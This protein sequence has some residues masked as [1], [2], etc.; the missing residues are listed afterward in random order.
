MLS[1]IYRASFFLYEISFLL[2]AFALAVY[3]ES[4]RRLTRALHQPAY[5]VLAWVGALGMVLCAVVHFYVYHDLSPQ[6][7][8][9]GDH[10]QLMLMYLLKTISMVSIFLTGLLL[11]LGSVL[12][13][14]RISR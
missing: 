1:L 9:S 13:L 14:R 11:I 10:E 5:W 4:W 7:L 12:Y 3:G 6:Y 8:V 2:L